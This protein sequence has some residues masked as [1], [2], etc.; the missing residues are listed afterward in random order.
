MLHLYRLITNTCHKFFIV[1]KQTIAFLSSTSAVSFAF[2]F[3]GS[4]TS[5]SAV[6]FTFAS[7][8]CFRLSHVICR[9]NSYLKSRFCKDWFSRKM[10][11]R[12]V[13]GKPLMSGKRFYLPWLSLLLEV[14]RKCCRNYPWKEIFCVL[15]IPAK[16][17]CH[18]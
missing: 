7:S 17:F 2:P 6:T 14:F 9:W 10:N 11:L 12:M 18:G 15:K 3:T 8:T 5:T 16:C 13:T 1:I 4:C